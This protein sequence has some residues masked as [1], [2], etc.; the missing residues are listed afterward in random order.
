MIDAQTLVLRDKI[1]QFIE[2]RVLPLEQE[3]TT[4]DE[5]QNIRAEPLA[6]LRAEVKEAGLWAP[7]VSTDEGGLGC[8]IAQMAVLYETL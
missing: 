4:F 6:A 2:T 8:S 5:H 7:Q 1:A 3:A